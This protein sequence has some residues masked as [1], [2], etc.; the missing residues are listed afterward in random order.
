VHTRSRAAQR[1]S[2]HTGRLGSDLIARASQEGKQVFLKRFQQPAH[3]RLVALELAAPA[4]DR[5]F[6]ELMQRRH[7]FAHGALDFAVLAQGHL[8]ARQRPSNVVFPLSVRQ[9]GGEFIYQPA[10]RLERVFIGRWHVAS[11]VARVTLEWE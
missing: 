10:Q 11:F 8:G 2:H 6:V 5:I 4:A 7:E 9:A 3:G 1:L